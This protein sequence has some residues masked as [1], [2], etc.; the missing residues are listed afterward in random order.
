MNNVGRQLGIGGIRI[1]LTASESCSEF[2]IGRDYDLKT[3]IGDEGDIVCGQ[4]STGDARSLSPAF[5]STWGSSAQLNDLFGFP[6]F[7]CAT[8]AGV[9]GCRK[10][11]VLR[12]MSVNK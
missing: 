3:T 12:T 6:F 11:T 8:A 1:S 7:G 5:I 4:R 9:L 10:V 2:G